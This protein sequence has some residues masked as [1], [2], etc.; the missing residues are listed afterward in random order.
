MVAFGN[1]SREVIYSFAPFGARIMSL[2]RHAA[3][4]AYHTARIPADLLSFFISFLSRERKE[5][6]Q[7]KETAARAKFACIPGAPPLGLKTVRS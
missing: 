7:R 2:T 5:T 4:A 6:K 1:K 3:F